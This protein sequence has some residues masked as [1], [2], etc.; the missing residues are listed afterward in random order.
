MR[1]PGRARVAQAWGRVGARGCGRRHRLD[2]L[3][4][5][6]RRHRQV[7]GRGFRGAD[8]RGLFGP[9]EAFR[10]RGEPFPLR[11][12][13]TH[14]GFGHGFIIDRFID[15]YHLLRPRPP[16]D[17]DHPQYAALAKQVQDALARHRPLVYAAGHDHS[18][19][20]FEADE[21][22]RLHIVSGAGSV[23]K[24]SPVTAVAGTI[25]AHAVPGFA[26]LDF[27]TRDRVDTPVVRIVRTGREA[28]AFQMRIP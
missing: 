24:V 25:F 21:V 14:A 3:A 28:P 16:L 8:R 26:V 4:L 5:I 22:A 13:G 11:S 2:A 27:T 10:D 17:L 7:P 15:F 1:R 12:G 20:L 23:G 19:Q 9:K 6:G 18:L